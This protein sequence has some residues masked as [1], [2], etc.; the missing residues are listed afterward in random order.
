MAVLWSPFINGST[1][2][3]QVLHRGDD[4]DRFQL[5]VCEPLGM[6]HACPG[7]PLPSP[8]PYPTHSLL[9]SWWSGIPRGQVL[10][11]PLQSSAAP[12]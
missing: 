1:A 10:L 7:L 3:R 12:P 8:R 6:P 9:A 11:T 4:D 5:A 2:G